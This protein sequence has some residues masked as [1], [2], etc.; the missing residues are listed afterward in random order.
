MT[1][2]Y[3]LN[4]TNINCDDIS[5]ATYTHTEKINELN[6]LYNKFYD[7]FIDI[8]NLKRCSKLSIDNNF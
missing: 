4:I 5:I 8:S 1:D 2:I 3:E 7:R 6:A